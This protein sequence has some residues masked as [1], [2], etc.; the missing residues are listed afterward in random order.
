MNF[1]DV[2]NA[3]AGGIGMLIFAGMFYIFSAWAIWYGFKD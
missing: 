1:W 3:N 2:L